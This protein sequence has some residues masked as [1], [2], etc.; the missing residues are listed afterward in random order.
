[1]PEI[2]AMLNALT[3]VKVS[4]EKHDGKVVEIQ[5]DGRSIVIDHKGTKMTAKVSGSRTKI[6]VDGKSAKR[7][8][9]QVGMACTFTWPKVNSEAQNIDCKK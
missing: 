8:A 2:V 5:D 6:T 3:Q 7:K 4:S 9:V 1:P